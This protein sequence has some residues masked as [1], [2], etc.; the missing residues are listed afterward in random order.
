MLA[1]EAERK[2]AVEPNKVVLIGSGLVDVVDAL[3]SEG[4]DV[5]TG[6]DLT[7][8]LAL[9]DVD[10][11]ACAILA[12]DGDADVCGAIRRSLPAASALL[13]LTDGASGATIAC[14]VGGADEVVAR[15]TPVPVL[16]ARVRAQ[17]RRKQ[18]ELEVARE[19]DT[20][21]ATLAEA[22]AGHLAEVE[23]KN[24]E[25]AAANAELEAF[26][27]SVSHDLR[28]PL[29][30]VDGF[31]RVLLE[32][33]SEHLDDD[34]KAHIARILGAAKRMGELIEDL[35]TLSR[36]TR[37]ELSRQDVDLG[38]IASVVGSELAE[39]NPTRTVTLAVA[40]GLRATA[41]ARLIRAVFESLLGNAWKF[42]RKRDDAAVEIGASEDTG[43]RVYFVRDNGVGFEGASAA[44]LFRPFQRLHSPK[45]FE[46]TG[47]GLATVRRIVARHGGRTWATS[48]VGEGACVYFTLG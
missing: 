38:E 2:H 35:L 18:R 17:L 29:R 42:T 21:A 32:D 26:S 20:L 24:A 30:A 7:E 15:S 45:D 40:G 39:R 41:D 11:P 22:R 36:V 31:S 9:Y 14:L 37:A 6:G 48:S 27:Y 44:K 16:A 8:A 19:R 10:A 23:K 47:I 4:F 13:A 25:L 33:C 46:G 12:M 5:A 28:A 3:R 43:E 1:S 34:G